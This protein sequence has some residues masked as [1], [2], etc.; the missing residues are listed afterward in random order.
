MIEATSPDT[1]IPVSDQCELNEVPSV[2][3]D[4]PWDAFFFARGGDPAKGFDWTHHF[5]W[6]SGQAVGTFSALWGQ[7]ENNNRVG[8][9]M[10]NDG[11]GVAMSH[12]EVGMAASLR[13]LGHEVIDLGLFEPMSDDFS[14]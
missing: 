12:P 9:L 8:L 13:K 11:D 14:V 3:A 2:S 5:F 10:A 6:G 7:L 4:T 1:V